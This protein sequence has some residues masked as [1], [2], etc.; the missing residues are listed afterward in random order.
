MPSLAVESNNTVQAMN[1][2]MRSCSVDRSYKRAVEIL[3]SRRRP[4]R[5]TLGPAENMP[6]LTRIPDAK[7]KPDL[8]GV[9]SIVG[10]KQ[11]LGQIGH[12]TTDLDRLNII[13]VAGTKGKGST[14]AFM[15]SFLR[16]AGKRTNFPRKTGLYTSPHLIFPEERI[17][18]N[19]EPL[20][21]DLFAEYF[22]EV[23]DA[24]SV[25]E[26]PSRL[27][28]RYLQLLALVGFHAFIKE[29]V[30]AAIIEC[31]HGGEYDAT[32]IIEHP[33]AAVITPLGIDHI[34]QLGPNFENIA[35]HKAGIFKPGTWAF[36]AP[37]NDP[38][39]KVLRKRAEEKGIGVE[40][41][42]DDPSL[43]S[44]SL[45]LKPDVQHKNCSL[46]LAAVRRFLLEKS[47]ERDP[48]LSKED[49]AQ[50]V[51]QFFWPGRFQL[52]VEE[53]NHWFL[54]GAHNEMSVSKAAQWFIESSAA[55]NA[56]TTRILIFSQISDQRDST[57]VLECLARALGNVDIHH[58][59][60]TLYTSGQDFESE[61]QTGDSVYRKIW[62][63][64]HDESII[65][66]APN[67][68]EALASAR[69]IGAANGGMSTL[70][71]GSQHLVG[72]A[73]FHLN[74]CDYLRG[75]E[76][77][78]GRETEEGVE[79][80]AEERCERDPEAGTEWDDKEEA[81]RSS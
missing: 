3:C 29:G 67:A 21:R 72:G 52:V 40:F 42:G 14:S 25:G 56:P 69:E 33:V 70:I 66:F 8:K 18:I 55:L 75:A 48:S 11:W 77:G 59:I 62:K 43:P 24:L 1:T 10:M 22:F 73:L 30:D 78:A 9:P 71:T 80:E 38:A 19:F 2:V 79:R 7:D 16:T 76:R 81:K 61:S 44:D 65:S 46:A 26:E 57:L 49:I 60:F 32:N 63:M 20:A 51:G 50:A 28:P 74:C 17:R 35:W 6:G 68:Q 39:P 37:Q 41:V 53:S 54:D 13:H 27:M 45:Q 64:T 34:K 5:P 12:T 31:H 36:S 4:K 58:V 47:P 23:W 15:E